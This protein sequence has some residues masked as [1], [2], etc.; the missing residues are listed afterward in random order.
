MDALK[1]KNFTLKHGKK[2][3]SLDKNIYSEVQK[4]VIEEKSERL[5]MLH[6]RKFQRQAKNASQK[7][8]VVFKYSSKKISLKH[9]LRT[10]NSTYGLRDMT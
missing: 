10:I 1:V 6:H 9:L 5:D 4:R 3:I 7:T 2:K 8:K